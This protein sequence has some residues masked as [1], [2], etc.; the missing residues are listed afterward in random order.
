MRLFMFVLA[1]AAMASSQA[2][3]ASPRAIEIP[4][5]FSETLLDLRDDVREAAAQRKRVMLYFGQDGCPYCTALMTTNFS[6]R[7]I[8]EK[9]RRD[10]VAIAFNIWGDREVT[11]TDGKAMS[12]KQLTARLKVQFTP[13]LIFLDEKGGIALRLNGYYAPE[14]FNAA[15]DY[16]SGRIS[17]AEFESVREK[18]SNE[19][20][21]DQPFFTR[22][23]SGKPLAMLFETPYCAECDALHREVFTRAEV[24][25]QLGK[26]DVMR[27]P[28]PGKEALSLKVEYVPTLVLLDARGREALR[29][30]AYFRPFHVAGALDYVASGAYRTEPSFQ[31]FLQLKS[32]RMRSRGVQVDLWK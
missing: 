28:V 14:R 1:F 25:E 13:T 2:Q 10:F 27:F 6:Q 17:R 32:D 31:R 7:A 22:T 9:T 29:L 30:E 23:R 15:L 4:A 21:N 3:P 24:L 19:S 20:L 11:W 18:K 16:A 8:V 12:E 26:F 5:W